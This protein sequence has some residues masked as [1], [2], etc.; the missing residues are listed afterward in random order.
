MAKIG[1]VS[2]EDDINVNGEHV[3]DNQ[4]RWNSFEE[5]RN[6]AK[7]NG[8]THLL[9]SGSTL[10]DKRK[11]DNNIVSS[12]VRKIGRFFKHFHVIFEV[13]KTGDKESP[14][15][16]YAYSKGKKV[17]GPICQL[18]WASFADE[19]LYC[20]LWDK[21]E[22]GHRSVSLGRLK[23]MVL[24]CGEL[25]ILH[26]KQSDDNKVDGLRRPLCRNKIRSLDYDILFNP[27]H[28]PLTGLYGKYKR[29]LKYISKGRK[30]RTAMLNFNVPNTQ[31]NR[32]A[33][34]IAYRN[35]KEIKRKIEEQEVWSNE[36]AMRIIE[37]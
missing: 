22:N 6:Y 18:L 29:R 23:F 21:L 10:C 3:V 19:N 25:N 28:T 15:G 1:Q 17:L 32:T 33:A 30:G 5:I 36:W 27:T 13:N 12:D 37:V 26:N 24:I 7:T 4:K 2:F 16:L 20:E 8:V 35:G 31:K 34:F 14:Y 11:R 9:F